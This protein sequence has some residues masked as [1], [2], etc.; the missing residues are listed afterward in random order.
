MR[1]NQ[2]GSSTI[3]VKKSAVCTMA[4]ESVSATTPASSA[5]S[6]ATS[7]RGSVGR[8]RPATMG[9]RSAAESLQPHPAPCDREVRGI[10]TRSY[11][12]WPV[13]ARRAYTDAEVEAA[14]QALSDPARLE[15]AQRV[16]ADNAPALQRILNQAL[17]DA[18]WFDAAHQ[19]H[20]LEAAGTA[21]IEARLQAVRTLLAEETRVSMLIGVAV[22]YELAHEL[23]EKEE[24]RH[25]NRS[26]VARPLR[27]PPV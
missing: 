24:T 18:N 3:G 11:D 7:T 10:V 16:V 27:V 2:Y 23:M 12:G 17:D 15:E 21:D 25:G 5:V 9:R 26:A 1:P 13:A 14:V 19:Q 4:S 6:A 8:G 22:G 20:V